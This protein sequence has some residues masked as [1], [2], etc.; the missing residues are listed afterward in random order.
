MSVLSVWPSDCAWEIGTI[1]HYSQDHLKAFAAISLLGL[2]THKS[3]RWG[4]RNPRVGIIWGTLLL[5]GSC[6][7][8]VVQQR[9]AASP[10]WARPQAGIKSA[11]EVCRGLL[12]LFGLDYHISLKPRMQGIINIG[13][14]EA[15]DWLGSQFSER[16]WCWTNTSRLEVGHKFFR[17]SKSS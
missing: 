3:W 6:S 15:D 9:R 1:H 4:V 5:S 17:D 14:S 12:V 2:V 7:P 13:A 10:I 16:E 8:E 11:S